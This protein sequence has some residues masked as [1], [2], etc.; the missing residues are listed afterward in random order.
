MKEKFISSHS[1]NRI[2][3][4]WNF[5]KRKLCDANLVVTNLA[6]IRKDHDVWSLVRGSGGAEAGVC[7]SDNRGNRRGGE[8]YLVWCDMCMLFSGPS[9]SHSSFHRTNNRSSSP[10]PLLCI[11]RPSN[12]SKDRFTKPR[13]TILKQAAASPPFLNTN[14]SANKISKQNG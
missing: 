2:I 4:E 9:R 8:R 5:V 7:W 13:P 1:T 14:Q 3:T 12:K 10:P 6:F 11:S